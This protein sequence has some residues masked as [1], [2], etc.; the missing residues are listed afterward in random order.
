MLKEKRKIVKV[1]LTILAAIIVILYLI[2]FYIVVVNA[3]K[4]SLETAENAL[5]FPTQLIMENLNK[6]AKK[7][8]LGQLLKIR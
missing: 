2:P 1:L 7:S 5:A 8:D 6:A 4:T 3:F